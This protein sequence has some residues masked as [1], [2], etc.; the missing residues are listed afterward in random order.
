MDKFVNIN[1]FKAILED[2][3]V[4]AMENWKQSG[5]NYNSLFIAKYSDGTQERI[6]IY[7]KEI[8]D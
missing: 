7:T 2:K 3:E 5:D 4:V 1:E 8:I 6:M